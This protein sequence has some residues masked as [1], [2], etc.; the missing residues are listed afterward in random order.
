MT[1]A[2]QLDLYSKYLDSYRYTPDISL[3]MM[4]AAPKYRKRK[5]SDVVYPKGSVKYKQNPG[6]VDAKTGLITV[7]SI[8]AYYADFGVF[9]VKGKGGFMSKTEFP[10]KRP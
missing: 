1:P 4:Q 5:G 6:W 7:D 9:P 8:N 2:E 10:K 3:G